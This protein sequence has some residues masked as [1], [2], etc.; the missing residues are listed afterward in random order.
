MAQP[1]IADPGR[2]PAGSHVLWAYT[3]VPANSALDQTEAVTRQIERFAP[4]FRDVILASAN[5]TA[6]EME[7][8]NPNYIG[9][10]IAGG[11]ASFAQLVA[12]PLV[13]TDPWSTPADGVYLCS[14]STPP[15]PG[16]H[17]L[18][19]YYAARSA[20][21]RSFGVTDAPS[22]ALGR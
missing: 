16:V 15:G 10:D 1:S 20:L 8:E 17:G 13:S 6:V 3:H 11:A 2:A 19:G 18:A 21:R 14:S 22:L 12:R 5:R 4:G 7:R 9:G